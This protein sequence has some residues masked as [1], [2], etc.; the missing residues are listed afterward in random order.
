MYRS[1]EKQREAHRENLGILMFADRAGIT[2]FAVDLQVRNAERARTKS[3]PLSRVPS[4]LAALPRVTARLHGIWGECDI[5]AQGTLDEQARVL[6]S[7]QPD[8]SFTVIPGAGHW[9]QYEA[10]EAYNR[11]LESLLEN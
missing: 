9:V 1:K 3:R 6:R 7:F 11:T 8:A 5:T 2:D 10:A 4:L